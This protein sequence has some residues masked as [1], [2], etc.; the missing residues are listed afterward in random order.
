VTRVSTKRKKDNLDFTKGTSQARYLLR[1]GAIGFTIRGFLT[2]KH[3]ESNA[4]V[5]GKGKRRVS[6]RWDG[7]KTGLTMDDDG[8]WGDGVVGVTKGRRRVNLSAGED[9]LFLREEGGGSC[10]YHINSKAKKERL[11]KE[12][13]K[14]EQGT[15]SRRKEKVEGRRVCKHS[16]SAKKE[17]DKAM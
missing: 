11:L 15:Q 16:K 17:S 2:R 4:K 9:E 6:R 8:R 3:R 7:K 10:G 12:R 14:I 5:C 1:G 13:K